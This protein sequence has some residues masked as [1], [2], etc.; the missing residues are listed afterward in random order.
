MDF[1]KLARDFEVE[2]RHGY[3]SFIAKVRCSVAGHQ[4]VAMGREALL[5]IV[6]RLEENPTLDNEVRY[7]WAA[8]ISR[9]GVE[10]KLGVPFMD[11]P[12]GKVSV[13]VLWA[14]ITANTWVAK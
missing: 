8:L 1:E 12:F 7:A 4:I 14:K 9:I 5:L 3:Q 6:K 2:I 10:R 11:L 13:W